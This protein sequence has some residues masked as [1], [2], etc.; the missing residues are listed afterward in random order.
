MKPA[1]IILLACIIV[2]ALPATAQLQL[3][4]QVIGS[5]GNYSTAG[6]ISIS[7]TVGEPAVTTLT[8]GSSILTQGFQQPTRF[9]RELDLHIYNGITPNNDGIN[10]VW[11]IDGIEQYPD[12]NVTI[13]N[14]WGRKVWEAKNY[15]NGDIAW[16]GTNKQEVLLP[17]GTYFYILHVPDS[18]PSKGWVQITR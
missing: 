3:S 5:T 13:F 10:D 11:F 4:R 12:N 17:D 9:I 15:N 1:S 7:S 2:A 18:E 8:G 16:D 6:G 14:R